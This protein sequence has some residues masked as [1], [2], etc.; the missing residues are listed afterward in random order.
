MGKT[1]MKMKTIL[2][3]LGQVCICFYFLWLSIFWSWDN[4]SILNVFI[5]IYIFNLMAVT[6]LAFIKNKSWHEI[7]LSYSGAALACFSGGLFIL[8]CYTFFLL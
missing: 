7:I 5:P 4:I 6:N 1:V 3:A 2:A 8:S